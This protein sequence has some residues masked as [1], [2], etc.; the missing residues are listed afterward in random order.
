MCAYVGAPGSQVCLG[1]HEADLPL[2]TLSKRIAQ[3]NFTW[4]NTNMPAFPDHP[5]PE[6]PPKRSGGANMPSGVGGA[7]PRQSEKNKEKKL[8]PMESACL[9]S[10]ECGKASVAL[11]GL[12]S[13]E[14]NMFRDGTFKVDT[15]NTS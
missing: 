7:D 12:L 11:L 6:L 4:I 15:L 14:A 10:S 8:L 9:V 3:S 1:N 2:A 13:D 5:H